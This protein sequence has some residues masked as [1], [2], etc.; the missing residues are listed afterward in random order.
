MVNSGPEMDL[1]EVRADM[2]NGFALMVAHVKQAQ[3]FGAGP[4]VAFG[5][6]IDLPLPAKPVEIVD[7]I[8]AHEGLQGLVNLRQIHS[9]LEDPVAI[10]I[11][12]KLGH[13]GQKGGVDAGN[14]RALARR[15]HEFG[16]VGGQEWNVL[17][18]PVFQH[19]GKPAGRADPGD[20]GRREGEGDR[21]RAGGKASGSG[22]P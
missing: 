4:V 10:H 3:V 1:V 13:R 12:I 2:R 6:D 16:D 19:Q 22:A 11:H 8:S 21:R 20:G 5:F 7:K 15:L 17:A 18:R 14:F 9:L